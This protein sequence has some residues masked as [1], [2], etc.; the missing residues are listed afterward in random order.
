[1]VSAPTVDTARTRV[2]L[3]AWAASRVFVVAVAILVG[4]IF[5][6][7]ERGVDAQVPDA[8]AVLGGWDT[9]WYLDIA[10][11]GY[12]TNAALV[13]DVFTNAAFFPLLP[14]LMW[15]AARIGLNPFLATLVIVHLAFLATLIGVHRLSRD[16]LDARTAGYA[17]WCVALAPPALVASLAYTEALVL[18]AAV[19]AAWCATR[20]RFAVAGLLAA[21]A[22]L[23]RPPG[24]LVAVL[25]GLLALE[26][27]R[28]GRIRRLVMATGP[29]V[30]AL[31]AFLATL[32]ATRGSWT[33]PFDAQSAWDRG[34]IGLGVVTTLPGQI[35]DA[36]TALATLDLDAG[37]TSAVRDVGFT[38]L[39]GVLLAALWRQEGGLRSPWVAYSALVLA[40][41]LSTG[42]F[43]SMARFGLMAF[44]LA[45]PAARWLAAR[46]TRPRAAALVA[47]AVTALMVAQ[48]I[49][50]A[51]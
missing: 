37:A 2:A 23:A 27:A 30:L 6:E 41:P 45:W 47:C 22:A 3:V 15:M 5:G 38:V 19:A 12:E 4:W 1:M 35:V 29:S 43:D 13:G 33:L 31:G 46:P 32:Q 10:R 24:I 50:R 36:V 48:L 44:P 14:G 20:G 40:V 9:T 16:R 26:G 17:T 49:I 8:L 39:Y 7:P 25:I 21:P 51:P 11:N 42:S 18:A 28:S 34:P